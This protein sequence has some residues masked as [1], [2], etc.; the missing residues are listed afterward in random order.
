LREE[1]D[2]ETMIKTKTILTRMTTTTTTTTTTS[3]SSHRTFNR[4]SSSSSS[5][6][7]IKTTT[8]FLQGHTIL[9]TVKGKSKGRR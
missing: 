8:I 3:T 5:S 9:P 6:S 2:N 4:S 1:R 7:L